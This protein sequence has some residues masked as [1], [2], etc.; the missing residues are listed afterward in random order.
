MSS[1]SDDQTQQAKPP[2]KA[3]VVMEV[4]EELAKL[5]TE[6]KGDYRFEVSLYTNVSLP[7][8]PRAAPMWRQLNGSPDFPAV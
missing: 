1:S 2:L 7:L 4:S 6:S 8:P 5:L 3:H